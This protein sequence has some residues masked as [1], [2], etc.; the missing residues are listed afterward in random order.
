MNL[1][2]NVNL[3]HRWSNYQMRILMSFSNDINKYV[4]NEIRMGYAR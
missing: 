4:S 2:Q 3:S 1:S